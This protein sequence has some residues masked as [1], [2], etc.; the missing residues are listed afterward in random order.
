MGPAMFVPYSKPSRNRPG[1]RPEKVHLHTCACMRTGT[2]TPMHA[3]TH[4]LE[5]MHT[6]MPVSL[7]LSSHTYIFCHTSFIRYIHTQKYI[8]KK[9]CS[10]VPLH[11][12]TL[13]YTHAITPS[14]TH[15]AALM[16]SQSHVFS[17]THIENRE[18][19]THVHCALKD[20]FTCKENSRKISIERLVPLLPSKVAFKSFLKIITLFANK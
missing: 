5:Y 1:E 17:D 13:V 14:H 6:E 19:C 9:T 7:I 15:S 20:A 12:Y 11:K 8:W 16:H 3:H 2:H 4:M 18:G 10:H